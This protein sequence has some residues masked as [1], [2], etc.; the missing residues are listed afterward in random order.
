MPE[1]KQL[2]ADQRYALRMAAAWASWMPD[3]VQ[4]EQANLLVEQATMMLGEDR[5][6]L[7]RARSP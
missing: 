5:G 4:P 6:L 1:L 2:S 7:R 3:G